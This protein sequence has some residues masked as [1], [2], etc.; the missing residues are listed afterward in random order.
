MY[1][2]KSQRINSSGEG[3]NFGFSRIK[4]HMI[5]GTQIIHR[6]NI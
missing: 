3:S 1:T 6:I 2:V 5:M 4:L